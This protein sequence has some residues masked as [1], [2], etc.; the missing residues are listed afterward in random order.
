MANR[1]IVFTSEQIEE[2]NEAQKKNK[3]K[4]VE[5]RLQVLTMKIEGKTLEEIS[6]RTAYN[7][8]YARSLVTKYFAKGLEAIIGK[9]RP[10]NH[11]NMSFE[12]EEA[13][14]NS[15]TLRAQKG[16]L[17]TVKAIK[18]AYEKKVGHEIGRGHIYEILKRHNW[19]KIKP[20]P[21]HPKKAS[22]TEIEVSK[23]L[24]PA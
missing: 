16:E 21:Q 14:V 4:N 5:R 11:R 13:F 17:I 12:E 24:T 10:G 19:R 18:A 8:T 3:N 9:K 1:K 20:R 7:P 22:E 2:I 23:K 6:A 15:F